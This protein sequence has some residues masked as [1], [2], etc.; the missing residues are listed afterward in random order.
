MISSE[1]NKA[2]T[3]E[4]LTS[5]GWLSLNKFAVIA[6]MSYPTA[7]KAAR[8]GKVEVVKVG[9]VNRVY[10]D[11]ILRFLSEGNKPTDGGSKSPHPPL[12]N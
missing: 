9:G 4:Q 3:L 7:L 6:D 1:T 10:K 2:K 11:E 5:Q 12:N 8:E